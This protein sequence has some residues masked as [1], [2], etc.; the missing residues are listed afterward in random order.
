MVW[1]GIN[2]G[3]DDDSYITNNLLKLICDLGMTICANGEST[4]SATIEDN[5][6]LFGRHGK[7][8][9]VVEISKSRSKEKALLVAIIEASRAFN[10]RLNKL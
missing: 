10:D 3:D 9:V 6:H 7:I 5:P 8:H 4:V 1:L 2:K